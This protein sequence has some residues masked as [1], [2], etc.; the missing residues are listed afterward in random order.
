MKLCSR[1]RSAV[2]VLLATTFLAGCGGT[3]TPNPSRASATAT[4][5]VSPTVSAV[6]PSASGVTRET[7][8]IAALP[9]VALTP[10]TTALCDSDPAST[11]PGASPSSL[12]CSDTL[13]LAS[14]VTQAKLGTAADRLYLQRPECSTSPCG[15][16]ETSIATVHA[17]MNDTHLVITVDAQAENVVLERGRQQ[18]GWPDSLQAAKPVSGTP[19]LPALPLELRN[20]TV[21]PYCGVRGGPTVEGPAGCFLAAVIDARPA[22]VLDNGLQGGTTSLYRFDGANAILRYFYDGT[23]WRRGAGALLLHRGSLSWDFDP[24]SETEVP[25]K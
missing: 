5:T 12:I 14:R 25:I 4:A 8:E 19:S 6:A 20:R 3:P 10:A 24:W 2:P 9:E 23:A 1:Q 18:G 17:W 7:I 11:D 21:V 13:I 22:E 16:T 15:S